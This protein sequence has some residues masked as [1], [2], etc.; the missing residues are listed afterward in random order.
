MQLE[1]GNI[2]DGKVTE[3]TKFGAFVEVSGKT[4][5]VHISEVSNT[6]V[7]DIKDHLTVGQEVKV[8]V[9]NLTDDGKISLSI[10]KALP[11]QER[12][13]K[14]FQ[15][16]NRNDKAFDK[17]PDRMNGQKNGSKSFDRPKNTPGKNAPPRDF[18]DIPAKYGTVNG[19]S[20]NASF[21]EMLSKFKLA[22]EE[23]FS[24]MKNMQDIKRTRPRRK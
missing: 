18:D 22:S 17:K 11:Q 21:E 10:K 9:I 6:F 12:P 13:R 7:N 16:Q 1:I 5:M 4:G 8:K 24:G 15:N 19:P 20:N 2:Y 14:N 23:K 3:I